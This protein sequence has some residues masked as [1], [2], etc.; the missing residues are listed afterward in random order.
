[1]Q[2]IVIFQVETV[3][4]LRLIT[5]R[6]VVPQM[7]SVVVQRAGVD[8]L[9]VLATCRRQGSLAQLYGGHISHSILDIGGWGCCEVR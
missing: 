7:T 2:V 5:I 3:V 4:V 6:L 1:M 8:M 9:S